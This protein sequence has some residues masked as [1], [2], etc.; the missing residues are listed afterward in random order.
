[1]SFKVVLFL[2]LPVL[3]AGVSSLVLAKLCQS[4][5]EK[6]ERSPKRESADGFVDGAVAVNRARA[7]SLERKS[8]LVLNEEVEEPLLSML[9]PPDFQAEFS[10]ALVDAQ[11]RSSD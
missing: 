5:D 11:Q 6:K 4:S 7:R 9:V 10:N 1:M 3:V 2:F 8:P